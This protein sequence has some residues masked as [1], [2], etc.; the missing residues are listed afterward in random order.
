[1]NG[2]LSNEFVHMSSLYNNINPLVKYETKTEPL[3]TNIGFIKSATWLIYVASELVFYNFLDNHYY[4]K[5]ISDYA[6]E[7]NPTEDTRKLMEDFF[8]DE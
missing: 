2:L 8:K 5:K 1:M 6:Y 7:Y 4:W 3:T